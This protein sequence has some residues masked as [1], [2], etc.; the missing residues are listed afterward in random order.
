MFVVYFNIFDDSQ[1]LAYKDNMEVVIVA[2]VVFDFVCVYF[3]CANSSGVWL[4]EVVNLKTIHWNFRIKSMHLLHFRFD[5]TL[6]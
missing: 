6:D 3:F 1:R 4:K 2:Y 5:H